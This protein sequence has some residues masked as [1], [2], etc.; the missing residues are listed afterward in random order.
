MT[1]NKNIYLFDMDGTLTPARLPMT[2]RFAGWF[3]KFIKENYVFIVSGSDIEKIKSQTPKDIFESV[4]GVYASMG[5][6]FYKQGKCVYV[7]DFNPPTELLNLLEQYRKN[8]K[9]NGALFPNYIELRRGMV[10]FSVLGRDCPYEER[11][12]YKIW[13]D[14]NGERIAIQKSLS[15]KF[16]DLDI[17][18][19]GNISMDITPK[20]YG[21][22]QTA[23][24]LRKEFPANKIIFT[25]DRTKEGGNDYSLAQA[26]LKLGN[27]EIIQVENPQEVM[28]MINV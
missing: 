11:I 7:K 9:Y 3:R 15:Q 10:N 24:L 5:N 25:G 26:L 16:K 20:G 1:P 2:K 12:K 18:L 4:S 27:A 17:S 8:T 19:G 22:E 23:L 28:I 6:E 14:K 13:D 21:K